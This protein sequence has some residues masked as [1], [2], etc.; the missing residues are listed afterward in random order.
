MI[1]TVGWLV[2]FFFLFVVKMV[3]WICWT[4]KKEYGFFVINTK[5][6][7][8]SLIKMNEKIEIGIAWESAVTSSKWTVFLFFCI[9][10]KKK[11]LVDI[12]LRQLV[13]VTLILLYKINQFLLWSYALFQT[14][15][16]SQRW[17]KHVNNIQTFNF[18]KCK[19]TK[20]KT[21]QKWISSN[22]WH[23]KEIRIR[24]KLKRFEVDK[25]WL[26][27]HLILLWYWNSGKQC[28]K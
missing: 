27:N 2:V 9:R 17:A 1:F 5:E 3:K 22:D 8:G 23:F 26:V 7:G 25:E 16:E 15:R 24:I 20:E 18:V 19:K 6:K 28:F 14:N 10:R 12:A 4:K 11:P 13:I 21:K